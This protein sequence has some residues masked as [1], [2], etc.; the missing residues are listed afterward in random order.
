MRVIGCEFGQETGRSI[1]ASHLEALNYVIT[2]VE[3]C[4]LKEIDL[5]WRFFKSSV[6]SFRTPL[7]GSGAHLVTLIRQAVLAR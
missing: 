2:T 7:V 3:A 6:R 5:F 4:F 1:R